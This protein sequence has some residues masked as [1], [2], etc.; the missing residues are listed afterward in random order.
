[1]NVE[2]RAKLEGKKKK[3]KKNPYRK[4]DKDKFDDEWVTGGGGLRSSYRST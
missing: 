3:K 2:R 4:K 1:M